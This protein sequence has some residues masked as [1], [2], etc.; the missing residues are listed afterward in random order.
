MITKDQFENTCQARLVEM[1]VE[2]DPRYKKRLRWEI[3]EIVAKNKLDYFWDLHQRK[4]RYPVNQNNLLVCKL[5]GICKDHEIGNEPNCEYGEYPDI[6]VDYLSNVRDY[7]KTEWAPLTFGQEYV[8]N[9][10]NYTTFGIKS[11]LI[12]MARVHDEPRDEIQALTKNLE[13]KDDEGKVLTWDAAMKLY[14]ELKKYCEEHKEVA[15]AAKRLINRNRGM[16]VHAGGLIIS[17][18]PL[19]DL[20]PLVKRK[21]NP[22]ASAWV[23]G[24]HGQDLQPVG[25]VKFDL[26]VISNLLQ[27]AKC[28]KLVK[29][30]KGLAGIANLP[31]QADWTDVRKWRNDPKALDMAD[32]GDLKCI[33][34][35][36]SDGIR[37]LARAGGVTCFEDLVAYTALFRPGPLGMKMQERYVE[38]KRGRERYELHPLLKPI[39]EKTYGVLSYQEQI[40]KILNVVGEIPLKDCELVRKAISKKKV[41]GFLSYKEQFILNG[42]KNLGVIE[43]EII[44]LWM[45]IEAFAEY[46]FNLSHAV[47]YTYISQ[48][49]LYLKAHYPHEFYTAVLSCESLSEKIKEYKMEAKVHGVEMHRLDINKSGLTFDLVGDTIYYGMSN[50]KGIGEEPAK[51]IVAGQPYRDF[52][53]FLARFGTDA[54]VLKPLIGL[55]C[56]KD[57]SPVTLWKFAEY[58]KDRQKKHDDKKKRFAAA[59]VRYQ[60]EFQWLTDGPDSMQLGGFTEENPFDGEHWQK[61]N[62]MEEMEIDKEVECEEGDEGAEEREITTRIE[63]DGVD[64]E[65]VEKKWFRMGKGTKKFNRLKALQALWRRYKK[66]IEKD[67]ANLLDLPRLNDF[68]PEQ[69]EI[70]DDIVKELRDPVACEE[71]YYGFAWVHDL[72][73]SPDYKGNLT[74]E[75]FRSN[76]DLKAAPVEIKVLKVTKKKG[77]KAEFYQVECEDATNE[78]AKFN[79]WMDDWERW[80]PEL[81]KGNLLRIRLMPP[82]GNYPTYTFES[83]PRQMRWKLPKLKEDDFR[84]VVMRPAKKL[85][86]EELTHEEV[87]G[88]VFHQDVENE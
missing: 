87:L 79:V 77:K 24:L 16:G 26:L 4:V 52:E 66:A 74:F 13:A 17:N 71:K 1:G 39:L 11:A 12:D 49:L 65:R 84:I 42:M 50:V 83:P 2:N 31:G 57:A 9:I 27:I 22:H 28:C 20:V 68:D 85:I 46:G 82:S 86:D 10:G 80:E 67:K 37:A 3:D 14:P 51:R 29:E 88:E 53:D 78:F 45:Q 5:L 15:D 48:R 8:C 25:L 32:K 81:K 33:F 58:Y 7:L 6:D 44:E 62:V 34:Q 19:H 61:Y 69:W 43:R 72:E 35:F 56:F 59:L 21:D 30:R 76:P 36:D 70:D 60:E 63:I 55:R 41:E 40:M 38:R 75:R 73:Q 54:N 64:I 23:E 18:S 47:A